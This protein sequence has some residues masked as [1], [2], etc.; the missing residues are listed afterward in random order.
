LVLKEKAKILNE[1]K[2]AE[3]SV[4]QQFKDEAQQLKDQIKL[5][6]IRYSELYEGN[7]Q[8]ETKFL[9]SIAKLNRK[10]S[11]YTRYRKRIREAVLNTKDAASFLKTENEKL[12]KR[13]VAQESTEYI[14][15]S[16]K[17]QENEINRLVTKFENELNAKED[18]IQ[19][20]MADNQK[21]E[22]KR[23]EF[24]AAQ[25][26]ITELENEIVLKDRRFEE[27]RM[28]SSTE[29]T[30]LQK[31]LTRY[32]HESKEFAIELEAK[33]S[34]MKESAKVMAEAREENFRLNEQVE[35]LQSLWRD[36]QTKLEKTTEKNLSLQKLNQE[37][38]MAI[39]QYRRDIR[40]LREQIDKDYIESKGSEA[41]EATEKKKNPELLEKIDRVL[42]NMQ[43]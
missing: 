26:Q 17:E 23:D 7:Q 33:K 25:S 1:R 19:R 30:D 12:N 10:I 18:T 38:S 22:A 6:E 3:E 24:E 37:L 16:S 27:F 42:A 32:R 29:M 15:N 5:L 21:L 28:Q 20:L 39:N 40:E 43:I 41:T 2:G 8:K 9:E 36:Q 35:N 4:I 13:L 14:R 34:E 31:S 11:R